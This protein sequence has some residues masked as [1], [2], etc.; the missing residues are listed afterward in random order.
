MVH[1]TDVSRIPYQ[2]SR[3]PLDIRVEVIVTMNKSSWR[4]NDGKVGGIHGFVGG[5][6]E[7]Q[8]WDMR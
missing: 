7:M 3:W 8:Q 1:D 4:V 5:G 2:V 6:W